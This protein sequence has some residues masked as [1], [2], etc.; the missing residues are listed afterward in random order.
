MLVTVSRS[1]ATKGP[2]IADLAAATEAIAFDV[3]QAMMEAED[4]TMEV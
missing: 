1:I 4:E 3:R 2:D